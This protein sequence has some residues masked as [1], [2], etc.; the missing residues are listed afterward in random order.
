MPC[1]T[2]FKR[3]FLAR[4]SWSTTCPPAYPPVFIIAK[5]V[6]RTPAFSK[7]VR[8]ILAG[9]T[10]PEG[11]SAA[12]GAAGGGAA[13]FEWAGRKFAVRNQRVRTCLSAAS[14]AMTLTTEGE[15][16]ARLAAYARA[17]NA[18]NEARSHVR[19]TLQGECQ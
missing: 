3:L 4:S 9:S 18:Y 13:V 11:S 5:S 6:T 2:A 1:S 19:N 16:E 7:S 17:V 14:T 15:P 8:G 10:T 12:S